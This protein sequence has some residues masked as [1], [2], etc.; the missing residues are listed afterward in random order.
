LGKIEAKFDYIWAK[1]RRNFGKS[2]QIWANLIRF[3]QNHNLTSSKTS[4]FLQLWS[5]HLATSKSLNL[6]KP[7]RRR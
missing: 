1:F 3:E 4:D 6:F 7:T 2:D 5:N